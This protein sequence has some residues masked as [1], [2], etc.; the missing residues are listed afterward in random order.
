MKDA[1]SNH[2]GL[3]GVLA[4]ACAEPPLAILVRARRLFPLP[5]SRIGAMR[6]SPSVSILPAV[7]ALLL[8]PAALAAQ[9]TGS[10]PGAQ[11]P[12]GCRGTTTETSSITLPGPNGEP[13]EFPSYPMIESV[14]PGSPAERGGMK[15]GDLVLVQDGHD[16]VGDPPAPPALAG[17]T[18]QFLVWRDDR[19]VPLTVV[20]GRWDPP[21][22]TPGVTRVCRPLGTG[23]GG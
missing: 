18:V 15:M 7:L 16:L 22:E 9:T 5:L 6:L 8:L 13:V 21:E 23:S 1:A 4:G 20:L 11:R 17:D 10:T 19:E 2:A 3:Q 14:Q 12:I